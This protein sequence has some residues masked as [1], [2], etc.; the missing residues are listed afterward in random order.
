MI[1]GS[2]GG[3]AAGGPYGRQSGGTGG[4]GGVGFYSKPITQPFSQPFTVGTGGP[5]GGAGNA[6]NFANVGTVNGGAQGNNAGPVPGN[7]GAA[8][9]APGASF[10]YPVYPFV[11]Q[12]SN[13]AFDG[14]AGALGN[15]MVA[16]PAVAGNAGILCVFENDG[17]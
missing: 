3:G 10:T 9:N 14:G 8:G 1:G 17:T 6:T 16:A 5:T 7:T 13:T 11:I 12:G 15:A 2:G 4:K